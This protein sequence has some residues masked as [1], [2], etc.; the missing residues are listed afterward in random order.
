MK[1]WQKFAVITACATGAMLFAPILAAQDDEEPMFPEF[2]DTFRPCCSRLQPWG[3]NDFFKLIPGYQLLYQ[4]E[5][6]DEEIE[7]LLIKVLWHT[8]QVN[9]VRCAIVRE[10]E[11]ADGELT[12]ISWN[13]FA[14]C[15]EHRG[16][17]YFGEH[18]DIYE[19][20]EVVSHDGAWLAGVGGARAGLIMPGYP[21]VGSRYY[22]EIAPEIA[23]DRAEHLSVTES[24]ITP[25]GTFHGVLFVE[26]SSPLEPDDFSYKW[27]APK[28]GL[29]KDNDLELIDYG[30]RVS[31][32]GVFDAEGEEDDEE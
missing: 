17:F 14:I 28:V 30:F 9:G 27:Y 2:Q 25:A 32:D 4:G 31:L 21:L 3:T 7:T 8:K 22:Q 19:D 26:E 15:R 12:E 23:L 5:N 24:I 16:V 11:W 10:M 20:G 6:E 18:V 1:T 29:V 13:Y